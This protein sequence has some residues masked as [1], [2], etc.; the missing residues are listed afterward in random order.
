MRFGKIL[1][2]VKSIF[3]KPKPIAVGFG[4]FDNRAIWHINCPDGSHKSFDPYE[5][6]RRVRKFGNGD[7]WAEA[8]TI[9][10][11]SIDAEKIP[12]L[13]ETAL[14]SR[15]AAFDDVSKLSREVFDLKELGEGNSGWT[16]GEA[17]AVFSEY[18]ISVSQIGD[19][20]LP[21]PKQLA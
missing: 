15:K 1:S 2:K 20:F 11:S 6:D 14:R 16:D 21:L 4:Y 18:L 17:F 12:A 7:Q 8:I 9:L 13:K 19:E 10:K 5:I 3:V